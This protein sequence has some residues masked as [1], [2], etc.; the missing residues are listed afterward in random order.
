MPHNC[1]VAIA[2]LAPFSPLSSTLSLHIPSPA[3]S[4]LFLRTF[5]SLKKFK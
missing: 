4:D 3:S 1:E 2:T 5:S